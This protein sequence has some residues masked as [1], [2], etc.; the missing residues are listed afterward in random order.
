M[1]HKVVIGQQEVDDGYKELK[2]LAKRL[3]KAM[4]GK[5]FLEREGVAEISKQV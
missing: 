1:P 3:A 2:K 4:D 5:P